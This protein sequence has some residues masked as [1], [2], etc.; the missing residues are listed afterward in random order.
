[1]RP[2]YDRLVRPRGVIKE[3]VKGGICRTNPRYDHIWK[4][5]SL[6]QDA[7]NMLVVGGEYIIT[8]E[9]YEKMNALYFY[10]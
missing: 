1:M 9:L 6:V 8:Q 3:N 7:K 4:V 5:E 2:V 10:I